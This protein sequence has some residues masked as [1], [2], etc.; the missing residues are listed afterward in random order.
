MSKHFNKLALLLAVAAALAIAGP[1][2]ASYTVTLS[3]SGFADQTFTISAGGGSGTTG[4]QTIGQYSITVTTNDS[5]PGQNVAQ[6]GSLLTQNSL[7]VTA[8]SAPTADL[9]ITVQDT[10]FTNFGG[11]SLV[12]NSL[13]TTEID[14]GTVSAFT[15]VNTTGNATP[16]VSL[17]GPTLSDKAA[18]SLVL[19]LGAGAT[20][21]LGNQT[22]IHNLGSGATDN[23]T[24]TSVAQTTAVPVPPGL[25][26]GL[27]GAV[28]LMCLTWVRRRPV[29]MQT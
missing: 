16:S 28:T 22:T 6:G 24:V 1:A 27:L 11:P 10:T 17:T 23:I 12:K 5:A 25:T 2:R 19:G 8:T 18:N 15:Y 26:M 7:V 14:A 4:P 20:F 9:V 29:I 21:T 13:S 3:E